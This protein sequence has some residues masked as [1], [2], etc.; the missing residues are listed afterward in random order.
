MIIRAMN[1]SDL[2]QVADIVSRSFGKFF[3]LDQVDIEL[4]VRTLDSLSAILAETPNGHFVALNDANKV[5]S[6]I[7][8]HKWGSL[9]WIGTFA[10]DPDFQ[11]AG[12]GKNLL[13]RA[14]KF[15]EENN[16]STIAL[17]T[18][19]NSNYNVGFYMKYG[20]QP[21]YLTLVYKFSLVAQIKANDIE[22]NEIKW[23][24][25]QNK[26]EQVISSI[27]SIS[28]SIWANLDYTNVIISTMER[29]QGFLVFIKTTKIIGFALLRNKSKTRRNMLGNIIVELFVIESTFNHLFNESLVSLEL[30]LFER[31]YTVL[32]ISVNSYYSPI[33]KILIEKGYI[34]ERTRVR[35]Y[36]KKNNHPST[37]VNLCTFAM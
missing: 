9:G 4:N 18:M 13:I 1:I 29:E 24:E 27:K 19:P 20:F 35:M 7:F 6:F 31:G 25:L 33:T 12:F 16:C 14:I 17:E 10:I 5:V 11:K 21:D 22:I 15:L 8:T 34:I 36:L 37:S 3:D 23:A 28:S 26:R 32:I 2:P 30:F